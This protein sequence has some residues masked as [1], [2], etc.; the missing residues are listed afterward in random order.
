MFRLSYSLALLLFGLAG[1]PAAEKTR[2]VVLGGLDP[3]EL[4]GG[5]ESPGQNKL[6][7]EHGKFRYQFATEA[8]KAAFEKEP[9]KYAVQFG[10][11]CGKM[12]PLSGGGNP[13]RFWVHEK[14]I[15]LFASESCRTSFKAAPEKHIDKPDAVPTGTVAEVKSGKELVELAV[16]GFGAMA[17]DSLASYQETQTLL[18]PQKDK[19]HFE[20]T[21]VLTWAPGRYRE[22]NSYTGWKGFTVAAPKASFDTSGKDTWPIEESVKAFFLRKLH[23][24][25]VIAI[26]A[27]GEKGF[28]AV[29]AGSGTAGETKVEYLTVGVHGATTTFALD[30]AGR[31][32]ESKH[33]NRAGGEVVK[34]F[35]DFRAV[36]GLTVP[37]KVG[38]TV[39]GKVV[40]NPETRVESVRVNA[41]LDANLFAMPE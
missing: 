28:V 4:V 36:D 10:G 41:K 13:E 18:Y 19:P 12:G 35:A 23:R 39:D 15:Y 37:F 40:T 9:A 20:M 29:A 5:K 26:A 21:Y 32:V 34:R 33:K 31:I 7:V 3:V 17:F 6:T 22:E 24:H 14:K 25:P 1:L 8:N 27:H 16:K 30:A 2:V 38:T 11:A